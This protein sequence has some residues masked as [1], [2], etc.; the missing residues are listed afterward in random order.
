MLIKKENVFRYYLTAVSIFIIVLFVAILLTLIYKSIL[1][2]NLFGFSFYTSDEWNPST[3]DYGALAFLVGTLITSF[4]ALAISIPFSLMISIFLGEYFREGMMSNIL[5]SMV[6]LLAGIPSIIYGIW[7]LFVFV[8]FFRSIQ[9]F[10]FEKGLLNV[11]PYGIGMFTAAVILSVMIIPY[12]ASIGRDVIA[13]VPSDLKEAGYSMGGTRFEVIKKI[14]LPYCRSGIFAGTMLSLG[15]AL[16]ETMAVTMVIGNRNFMPKSIFDPAST[17]ASVLASEFAESTNSIQ[18][19][20]LI[21]LG[22]VLF[23]TTAVINVIGKA[24]IKGRK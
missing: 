21:H 5:K 4:L 13:L 19:S 6:E 18:L 17:L 16:G 8:P 3:H 15:R 10:L 23:L 14:I 11:P 20:S 2:I 24:I 9:L 12:S 7:G 22:L 1:S